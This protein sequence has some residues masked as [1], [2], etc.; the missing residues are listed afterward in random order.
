MSEIKG[1][2][3]QEW[4]KARNIMKTMSLTEMRR[5][6]NGM[7]SKFILSGLKKRGELSDTTV[8]DL[9]KWREAWEVVSAQVADTS[10]E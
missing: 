10:G 1:L 9:R 3:S 8:N 2:T 7:V 4:I 6:N 5:Q